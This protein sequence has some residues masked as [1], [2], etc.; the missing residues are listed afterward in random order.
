M[1][2]EGKARINDSLY[3]IRF[4][5]YPEFDVDEGSSVVSSF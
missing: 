4:Y 3:I 5:I 2:A 1:I